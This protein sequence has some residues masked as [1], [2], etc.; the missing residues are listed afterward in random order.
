MPAPLPGNEPSARPGLGLVKA[1]EA[2]RQRVARREE[3]TARARDFAQGSRAEST[4]EAYRRQWARFEE[5]CRAA[6]EKAMP[7]EPLT[8]ARFLADVA[9]VWRAATPAD[10]HEE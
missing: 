6:G 10:P 8:V 7:A 5:W 1:G 3:L 2:E 9:P 4:W